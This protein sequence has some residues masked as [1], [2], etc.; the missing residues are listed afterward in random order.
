[1]KKLLTILLVALILICLVGCDT[2]SQSGGNNTPKPDK[3]DGD[4]LPDETD[5]DKVPDDTASKHV[6]V[7]YFSCTGN[8]KAVAQSLAEIKGGT[9]FEIKPAEPYTSADL[10]YTD[11]GCRANREQNDDN[12]RPKII[13]VVKNVAD[14]DFVFV[15]YPIWWGKLP[16]IL[17]TFFDSYDFADKT[18]IPFCTS[19]GSGISASEAEI[20]L[21]EPNATVLDGKRFVGNEMSTLK[22]WV[23]E[24]NLKTQNNKVKVYCGE[25]VLEMELADNASAKAF[26][27]RL[28]KGD[29][30]VTMNDYGNFE[31]VGE[32]GFEL[33]RTDENI[34]T[35]PGDVILYLGTNI[36]IYYDTNSW[37]FTLLGKIKNM[38]RET[39]LQFFG[40]KGEVTVRFS[41]K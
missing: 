4:K 13:D 30:T 21:L 23:E 3:T 2:P 38:T 14:Y 18:I 39:M 7:A 9:L 24:L 8:T 6:L 22:T 28:Q 19:G 25:R 15:G 26:E 5:G 17:Y 16:K 11:S 32:L 34:T 41:I 31:K 33:V 36:T 37:N 27:E 1:M 35:E 20:K 12:A 10:N 40:G 29:V